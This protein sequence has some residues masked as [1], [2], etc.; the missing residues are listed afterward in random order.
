MPLAASIDTDLVGARSWL[1]GV[2]TTATNLSPVLKDFGEYMVGSVKRNFAAG[3]R[4]RKWQ[5]SN[6][7]LATGGKTLVK[8]GRLR[9][10]LS[11]RVEGKAVNVGTNVA[12]AKAH[13]FGVNKT[14]S[15]SVR[16]HS[17]RT[18]RGT[19][20]VRAHSRRARLHLP[21][22]PFLLVQ[23]EDRLYLN[24]R[25]RRHFLTRGRR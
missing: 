2:K 10:S 5:P 12:Y 25:L 23:R 22:R 20:Q 3:G 18:S 4:P 24:L 1:R 8:T 15:Q 19:V 16:S 9:S 21:A 13:H 6:R 11:S 14:V 7:A 17:R